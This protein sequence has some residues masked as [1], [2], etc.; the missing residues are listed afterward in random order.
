MSASSA[1]TQRRCVVIGGGL[2]G[3]TAAHALV[4]DPAYAGNEVLLVEGTSRVGGKLKLAEVA[5]VEVDVGAEA[6]LIRRH[7]GL[8]LAVELGLD[9]VTPA[10]DAAPRLWSR[11]RLRPLPRTVLGVPQDLRDLTSSRVLSAAGLAAVRRELQ[12]GPREPT[13]ADVSVGSL[14]AQRMGDEVVD[15]LVEP[16]LGGVYA[17]RAYEISARAAI[18]GLVEQARHG[19]WLA[20]AAPRAEGE[21]AGS[22]FAGI[23]GGVAQLAQELLQAASNRGQGRFTVQYDAIVRAI[24]PTQQGFVI[25]VANP[26]GV[27]LVTADDVVVATPPGAAG[28]LL[29][30]LA[31]DAATELS[32]IE[33]ASVAIVTLAV[34]AA[35]VAHVRSS[36]FLVPPVER[37]G[38]KAATFSWA[39]WDW[40]RQAGAHDRPDQAVAL[41]RASWGRHREEWVL[42]RTDEELVAL[43]REDLARIAGIDAVPVAAQVQRWGGGI[44]QYAVGHLDR[45]ARIRAAV[46][47]ANRA[48]GSRLAVCGAAYDGVG[49]PA[50]IAS[51]QRAAG[52]ITGGR[53][54]PGPGTMG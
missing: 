34:P 43:T 22:P 23:R 17:G 4:C 20:Q 52:E 53:M 42:Q 2:A 35:R 8:A 46:A 38:I 51:A 14:V 48:D 3:L 31:P 28:R 50:V 9:V 27:T 45:V 41:L 6:I 16:L 24:A 37:T 36:G 47:R 15:R 5:G 10:A 13:E 32:R 12:R 49:I 54:A 11:G 18:P 30:A 29:Q 7:E 39:K 44:P 21:S 19:S 26:D 25:E 1:G 33:T 40:I